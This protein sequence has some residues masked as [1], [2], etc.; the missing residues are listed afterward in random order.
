MTLPNTSAGV[1]IQSEGDTWRAARNGPV[2]T[3]GAW[4]LLGAVIAVA[5]FFAIRWR[6][7][8]HEGPAGVTIERFKAVERFAHWLMA[9]CS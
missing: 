4:A 5:A 9:G 1:L 3:Y 6:I 7:R 8:I 2:S